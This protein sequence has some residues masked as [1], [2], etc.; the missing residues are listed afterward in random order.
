MG[1]TSLGILSPCDDAQAASI[2]LA[3]LAAEGLTRYEQDPNYWYSTDE[4]PY[5]Y[6]IQ[7]PD[8]ETEP[9]E[10]RLVEQAIGASIRCEVLL[11]IFVSN[12]SGR[13]L[14]ARLA[15]GVALRIDGWVFVEFSDPPSS[16]LLNYL[17]QAGRSIRV[18]DAVYLDAEAMAAWIAHPSF[19]VVK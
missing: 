11:H 1:G 17:A 19:H 10:L 14:L 12:F 15:Q 13:P 8:V 18:D 7:A 4:L 6:D 5:G 2:V 16:D 9:A 3:A